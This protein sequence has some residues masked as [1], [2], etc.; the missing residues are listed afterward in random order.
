[1]GDS[2]VDTWKAVVKLQKSSYLAWIGY[3]DLLTKLEKYDEA[4]AVFSDICQRK[5]DWPETIWDSWIFFENLYGDVESLEECLA[6]VEKAQVFVNARRA[7]VGD[8]NCQKC[9]LTHHL[10]EAEQAAYANVQ[11]AAGQAATD[12]PAQDVRATAAATNVADAGAMDVDGD[13]IAHIGEGHGGTKRKAGEDAVS[14]AKKPRTGM[15]AISF[16]ALA[17]DTTIAC[18]ACRCCSQEVSS[19]GAF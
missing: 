10:Q 13:A 8:G 5:I 12:V 9:A 18:R 19:V 16:H 4:R 2:A 17:T 11:V 15:F 3:T 7:K 1:M 14:A 6:K